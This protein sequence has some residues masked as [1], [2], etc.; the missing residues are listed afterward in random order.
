[1]SRRMALKV[2]TL[3]TLRAGMVTGR[4]YPFDDDVRRK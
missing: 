1:M 3:S 2:P 4:S